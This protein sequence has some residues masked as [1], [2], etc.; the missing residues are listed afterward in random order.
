MKKHSIDA[1]RPPRV[2]YAALPWRANDGG[3]LEVLLI[4]SRGTRRWVIPKGWP[5]KGLRPESS[6]AREAFEEAGVT[7][8]PAA[9]AL[10]GYGYAKVLRSGRTREVQ[11]SVFALEVTHEAERWPEREQREKRWA[12]PEIA[13]ELVDEP[14]LQLLIRSFVAGALN[15]CCSGG[16]AGQAVQELAAIGLVAPRAKGDAA[17]AG[18]A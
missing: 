18:P 5:I 3:R 7:G 9:A 2:Q 10:G 8:M 16:V 1:E 6:A 11:V 12:P 13:A 17:S 15:R 14:E 4:T